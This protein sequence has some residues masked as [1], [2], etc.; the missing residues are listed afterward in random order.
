MRER[1][2]KIGGQLKIS[3]TTAT[4]TEIQLSIPGEIAF[5]SL[6]ADHLQIPS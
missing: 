5:Q 4:G 6:P 1:A 2:V 3:S